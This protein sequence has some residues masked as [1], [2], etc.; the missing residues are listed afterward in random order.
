VVGSGFVLVLGG[1]GFLVVVVVILLVVG[2][3]TPGVVRLM[4]SVH[5]PLVQ[6][7]M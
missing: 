6:V 7:M 3:G 2:S 5:P 1:S 4:L